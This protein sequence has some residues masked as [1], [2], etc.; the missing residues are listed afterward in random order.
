MFLFFHKSLFFHFFHLLALV[1]YLG[2]LQN[3]IFTNSVIEQFL[4][5]YKRNHHE[6]TKLVPIF[7]P[8]KNDP[9]VTFSINPGTGKNEMS[10]AYGQARK[11]VSNLLVGSDR[12]KV[13]SVIKYNDKLYICTDTSLDTNG[14]LTYVESTPLGNTNNFIEY[15]ANEQGYLIQS[16]I[17]SSMDTTH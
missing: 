14:V 5:Q 11:E 8:E 17:I 1:K 7:S 2:Q 4:I 9:N 3:G 10:I 15:N 13:A 12:N 6:S 16:V